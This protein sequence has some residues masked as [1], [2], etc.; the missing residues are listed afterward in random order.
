MQVINYITVNYKPLTTCIWAI[1]SELV[2]KKLSVLYDVCDSISSLSQ[3]IKL[4]F[5]K[6]GLEN[7][8]DGKCPYDGVEIYD[9]PTKNSHIIGNY[10]KL[11]LGYGII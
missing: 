1:C 10:I 4:H 5:A 3:V 7:G 6:F 9:G 8:T 11:I 2:I